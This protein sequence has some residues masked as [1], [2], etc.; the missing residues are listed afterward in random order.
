V[1][2]TNAERCFFLREVALVAMESMCRNASSTFLEFPSG[3]W[4]TTDGSFGLSQ[5][6][7][8]A[9]KGVIGA[10]TNIFCVSLTAV[11]LFATSTVATCWCVTMQGWFVSVGHVFDQV[12]LSMSSTRPRGLLALMRLKSDDSGCASLGCVMHW[13]S[14]AV[15]S[16]PSTDLWRALLEQADMAMK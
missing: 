7:S 15:P 6:R 10:V 8:S 2:G 4:Y 1:K 16:P 14:G 3:F 11:R 9:V 5:Y 12:H 13:V